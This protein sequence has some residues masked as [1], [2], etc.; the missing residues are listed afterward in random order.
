[1]E[2]HIYE[3]TK[4]REISLMKLIKAVLSKLWLIILCAAVFGVGAYFYSKSNTVPMYKSEALVN[5]SNYDKG[6]SSQNQMSAASMEASEHVLSRYVVLID[7]VDAIYEKAIENINTLKL[8]YAMGEEGY[9]DLGF[10]FDGHVTNEA[11]EELRIKYNDGEITAN[12]LLSL[13]GEKVFKIGQLRGMISVG[14]N[15]ET[16]ILSIY[17]SSSDPRLAQVV[18]QTVSEA[19]ATEANR[20]LGGSNASVI[21]KAKAATGPSSPVNKHTAL[22]ACLGALII[23]LIVV[24]KTVF[25][26]VV[27]TENDLIEE[28]PDIPILGVIPDIDSASS[29][30]GYRYIDKN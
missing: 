25:D 28:F 11:L 2:Y 27:R 30:R 20:L 24:L 23:I 13:L 26:V 6:P 29:R 14:Q 16:E 22:G 9:E 19:L 4:M 3:V 7:K 15:L 10:L 5:I 17:A 1:M 12:E 21:Q 18:A 8:G